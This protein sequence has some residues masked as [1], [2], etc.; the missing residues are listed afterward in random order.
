MWRTQGTVRHSRLERMGGSGCAFMFEVCSPCLMGSQVCVCPAHQ[1]P[2]L[3]QPQR[4]RAGSGGGE[5]M[6]GA[7]VAG[8]GR[9]DAWRPLGAHTLNTGTSSRRDEYVS[10]SPN[11]TP[12]VAPWQV[13]GL[14]RTPNFK[15]EESEETAEAKVTFTTPHPPQASPLRESQSPQMREALLHPEVW[16][17]S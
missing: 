15:L 6:A 4:G 17:I 8:W 2:C 9:G 3:L 12:S 7:H 5:C 16:L 14:G 10:E 13:I 1:G 11:R